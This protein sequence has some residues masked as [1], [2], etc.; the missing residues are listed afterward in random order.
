M[1]LV[2]LCIAAVALIAAA[3][4]A[5][6]VGLLAA[7]R[8][9]IE[10]LAPVARARVYLAAAFAPVASAALL[11][12]AALAPSFGW[13]S[14]H[15]D[16]GDP[17]AHAHICGHHVV[18]WPSLLLIL[19]AALAVV[20][21]A[22]RLTRHGH[23][24]LR[25]ARVRRTLDAASRLD[26][27]LGAQIL[28]FEEPRAFVLGLWR[29]RLYVTEGL[30][31]G[32]GSEHLGAVLAH[33]RAHIARRDPFRRFVAGLGLAFHLPFVARR[34][35]D[36]LARAQEM[37][38][39]EDAATTLASRVRVARALVALARATPAPE[40]ATAFATSD[41]TT[42]VALLMDDTPRADRPTVLHFV[43]GS[44]IA[45]ASVAMSADFVHHGVEILLGL[46]GS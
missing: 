23:A 43:I 19:I 39:D 28:P 26:A 12:V 46:F 36:A 17:H 32:G 35:D 33:E 14:D 25:A 29:P 7:L 6:V 22:W 34:L 24:L 5:G 31:I 9:R 8:P 15:C 37:A 45:I 38:A 11:I 2:V 20:R 13:I 44:A 27:E 40:G 30:V 41:V 10:D 1:T 4:S 18:A 42:R 16:G 21:G 3:V